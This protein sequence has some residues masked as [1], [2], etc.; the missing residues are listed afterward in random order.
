MLHAFGG[1]HPPRRPTP[2]DRVPP[3]GAEAEIRFLPGEAVVYRAHGVGLVERIAERV[4]GE[5]RIEMIQVSFRS[6]A[7]LLLIPRHTASQ[8]G[9]RHVSSQEVTD[10]AFRTIAG[11]P[12]ALKGIWAKKSDVIERKIS[13]GRLDQLAEVVRDLRPRAGSTGKSFSE[14]RLFEAAMERLTGE[15]AVITGQSSEEAS[16]RIHALLATTEA[17]AEAPAV[18]ASSREHPGPDR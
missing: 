17:D 1:H 3:P 11:R 13:S 12:Q 15:L 4:I 16:A 9:L 10:A 5:E 8:S 7:M 14:R 18:P 2:T 6:S